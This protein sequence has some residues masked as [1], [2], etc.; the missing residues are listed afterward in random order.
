V[1]TQKKFSEARN[2]FEDLIQMAK[3]SNEGM[4]ILTSSLLNLQAAIRVMVPFVI[5]TKHDEIESFIGT[6][7]PN[8]VVIHPPNDVKSKGRC[9]RIKKSK[10]TKSAGKGKATRT[11]SSCKQIGHHDARTCPNKSV[12]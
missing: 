4:D 11:C 1:A 9:K 2:M 3:Q 8:E 5:S 12:P 7:I 10:E 6:K